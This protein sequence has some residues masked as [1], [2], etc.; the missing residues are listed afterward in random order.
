MSALLSNP[1]LEIVGRQDRAHV[2]LEREQVPNRVRVFGAIQSVGRRASGIRPSGGRGVELTLE[3]RREGAVGRRIGPRTAG[4]RHRAGL[5]LV[6][7][8]LPGR[9]V[10]RDRSGRPRSFRRD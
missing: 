3:P 9:G 4:R 6:Q 7:D 5:E 2:D 8:L 10:L 1:K